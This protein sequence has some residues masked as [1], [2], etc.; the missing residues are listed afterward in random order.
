M[1]MEKKESRRK[2]KEREDSEKQK[3]GRKVRRKE[4]R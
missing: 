1:K 2:N 3:D 4:K